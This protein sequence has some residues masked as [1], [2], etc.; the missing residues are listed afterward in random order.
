MNQPRFLMAV[1]HREYC[2]NYISFF[3]RNGSAYTYACLC[4]GTAKKKTLD[5]L[6]LER[7][8]MA[9]V[10]C[11]VPDD[12][13]PLMKKMVREF[14]I[15]APN[16][17]IA[18]T[19]A[20]EINTDSREAKDMEYPYALITVIAERGSAEQVMDL[21]RSAGATGGTV[22]HGRGIGS[23]LSPKFFGVSIAEEKELLYIITKRRLRDGIVRVI[24][25]KAG[26]KSPAHAV[27]FTLP[28]DNVV[29]LHDMDD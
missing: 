1:V 21:A 3:Q 5:L 7:R 18:F 11:V 6:G 2:E 14:R 27:V 23:T 25:E 12:P 13:R 29:G 19:I 9:L 15:D 28:V 24:T 26:E 22:V 10:S 16:T 8:D 17:G 4:E 20:E